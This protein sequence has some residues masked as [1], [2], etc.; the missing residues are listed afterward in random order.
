MFGREAEQTFL[1]T[2]YQQM[3]QH[4]SRQVVTIN[5]DAGVGKSRL[6]F[7]FESWVDLQPA[8]VQIW[9]GRARP[10]TQHLPYGLLR[11]LFAF[12]YQIQRRRFHP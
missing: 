2:C 4:K 1:Q 3:V 12:R 10:D 7:E 5:A 8:N 6:L 11:S 9:R